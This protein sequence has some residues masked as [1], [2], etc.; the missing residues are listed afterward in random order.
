MG[1]Q[2]VLGHLSVHDRK[3]PNAGKPH[4]R[5]LRWVWGVFRNK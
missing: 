1:E 3:K 2:D 5:F 4:V